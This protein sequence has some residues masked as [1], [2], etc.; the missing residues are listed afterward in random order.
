[1]IAIISTANLLCRL[2]DNRDHFCLV[3]VGMACDF[4]SK[5][6]LYRPKIDSYRSYRFVAY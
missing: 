3:S 5:L 6:T 4:S 2:V 1:M